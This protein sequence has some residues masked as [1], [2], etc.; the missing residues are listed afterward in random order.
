[1]AQMSDYLLT[2]QRFCEKNEDFDNCNEIYPLA[3]QHF[4]VQLRIRYRLENRK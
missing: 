1:M 3:N 2:L 4:H